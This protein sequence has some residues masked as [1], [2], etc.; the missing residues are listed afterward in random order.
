MSS[1]REELEREVAALAEAGAWADLAAR[2]EREG[3]DAL[4]DDSDLSYRFGEA[5]YHTGRMSE[6]AAFAVRFEEA[7]RESADPRGIMRSL[8]LRGIAAFE[9]GQMAGAQTAFDALM[10]MAEAERDEEMLARAANNL[11]AIANLRGDRHRAL[12][13]YHL[14]IPLYQRLER[15]RGLAQTFHNMGL[16]CL[17]LGEL[18]EAVTFYERAIETARSISYP[19]VIAMST[20]GRAEAELRLGD[21][22]LAHRLAG[23]G[24]DVARTVPD[25][26][27]ETDGRR[28]LGLASAADGDLAGGL[29]EVRSAL[30]SARETGN[31]LQEA[32]AERDLG[33]LLQRAGQDDEAQE[34]LLAAARILEELGASAGAAAL[35]EEAEQ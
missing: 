9:L 8:N 16:A 30:E 27:T 22:P 10:D 13:Y 24:I 23:R 35:R 15:P 21:A 1:R 19:P 25:P 31:R 26:I 33:R 14:S 2:L 20:I 29:D 7:A 5:L 28:V 12:A 11:G 34:R 17:D 4:L 32:E 6:L 3:P 18:T